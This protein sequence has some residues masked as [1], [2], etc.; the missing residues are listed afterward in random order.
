MSLASR[1]KIVHKVSMSDSENLVQF[2]LMLPPRLKDRVAE[3]AKINRRSLSQEI[4]E[5]LETV[6]PGELT[7]D[8]L[9]ATLS[10]L[11]TELERTTDGERQRRIFKLMR[12]ASKEL[13]RVASSGHLRYI[14]DYLADPQTDVD[15][16]YPIL[17]DAQTTLKAGEELMEK[18]SKKKG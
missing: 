15:V 12:S 10:Y 17:Q 8:H 7:A 13:R 11:I 18:L 14:D 2:K 4:V 16:A 5:A 1:T 6:Y 9:E 3:A